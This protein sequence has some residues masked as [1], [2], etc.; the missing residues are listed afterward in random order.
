MH[1]R[2]GENT[3]RLRHFQVF[4]VLRVY[5]RA[6]DTKSG[7]MVVLENFDRLQLCSFSLSSRCSSRKATLACC[8]H[9]HPS[10]DYF[11]ENLQRRGAIT[12]E[13]K[14]LSLIRINRAFTIR[15]SSVRLLDNS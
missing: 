1:L 5:R 9:V 14:I 2:A 11:T 10:H 4:I 13:S 6:R 15:H 3:E 7:R 8:A 12:R